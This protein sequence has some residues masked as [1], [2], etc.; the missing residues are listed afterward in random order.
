MFGKSVIGGSSA[1][2]NECTPFKQPYQTSPHFQEIDPF[3]SMMSDS[4]MDEIREIGFTIDNPF[5]SATNSEFEISD[6]YRPKKISPT[7]YDRFIPQ[8]PVDL[9]QASNFET[10]EFLFSQ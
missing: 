7:E 5:E 1:I 8:R 2:T 9:G 3:E 6:I 4:E 10:K